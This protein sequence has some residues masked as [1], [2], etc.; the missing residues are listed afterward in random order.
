MSP[1]VP[2]AVIDLVARHRA[3]QARLAEEQRQ[4]R[5]LVAAQAALDAH[6]RTDRRVRRA[7]E[8]GLVVVILAEL[9]GLTLHLL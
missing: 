6:A 9:V 7:I 3:A 2:C 4:T 5:A 8:G 1:P